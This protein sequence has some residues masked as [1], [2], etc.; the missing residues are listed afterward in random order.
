[1]SV[2]FNAVIRLAAEYGYSGA[3][4]AGPEPNRGARVQ[5]MV[6]QLHA[7]G[8]GWDKVGDRPALETQQPGYRRRV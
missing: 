7:E 2:I 4:A 1:M 6:R 3:V 8:M 5:S